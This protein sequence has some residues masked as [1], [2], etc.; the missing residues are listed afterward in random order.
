MNS[1]K[2]TKEGYISL[3]MKV[4][5]QCTYPHTEVVKFLVEDTGFGIHPSRLKNIFNLFERQENSAI[6]DYID[7]SSRTAKVGLPISQRLCGLMG[8]RIL[9]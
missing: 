6:D 1:I 5:H 4:Y 2:F 3:T 9:V 8:G 7:M